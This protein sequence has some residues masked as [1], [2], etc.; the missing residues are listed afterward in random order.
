MASA[1]PSEPGQWRA[2]TSSQRIFLVG[3]ESLVKS[4]NHQKALKQE[5]KKAE[6]LCREEV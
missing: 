1:G 6:T 3:R 5:V 2:G 4:H